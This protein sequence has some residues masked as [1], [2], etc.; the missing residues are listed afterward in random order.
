MDKPT[1]KQLEEFWEWCGFRK[2]EPKYCKVC[3]R[4]EPSYWLKEGIGKRLDEPDLDLNNLFRYAVPNLVGINIER[5]YSVEDSPL[6]S[7][8]VCA[9][10]KWEQVCNADLALALFWAIWEVIHG[11]QRGGSKKVHYE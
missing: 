6:W 1:Y 10:S 4:Q 3:K 7:V 8:D 11:K 9:G 5:N 2:V